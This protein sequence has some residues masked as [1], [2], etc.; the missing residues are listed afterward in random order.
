MAASVVG[1][2]I[3]EDSV[4]VGNPVCALAVM[5]AGVYGA[6]PWATVVRALF[7]S[8]RHCTLS[9][10][11]ADGAQDPVPA[12]TVAAVGRGSDEEGGRSLSA[13]T[14]ARLRS[15]RSA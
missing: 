5:R 7:A 3:L 8:V 12:T 10:R 1:G 2:T 14:G 4:L 11:L 15:L 6:L 13:L 9:N